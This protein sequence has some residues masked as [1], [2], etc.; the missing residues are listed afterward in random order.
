MNMMWFLPTP[1]STIVIE[2]PSACGSSKTAETLTPTT[3][4]SPWST[5]A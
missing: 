5:L 1:L 2:I 3:G 4:F